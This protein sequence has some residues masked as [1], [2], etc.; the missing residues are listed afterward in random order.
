MMTGACSECRESGQQWILHPAATTLMGSV[1]LTTVMT[2][3][4]AC[5][6]LVECLC[7]GVVTEAAA[8]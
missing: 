8:E 5:E 4:M 1:H 2:M 7:L 6:A 3:G